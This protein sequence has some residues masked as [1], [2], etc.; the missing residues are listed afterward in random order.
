MAVSVVDIQVNSSGAVRSLQQL[1][2]AA[3]GVT[4]TI[5][6][7]AA[8]LGA[9]F[10]LQQV[11][12]TASEFEST[13]S[14]IGKTAGSSQKDILKLADSL[15]QL[16]MPSRTNLAPSV[17]A[18]GVQDLVAQGLKLDD[19]VASIETLGKVAV[20]T[21]SDLTD[22]T[23]TGFQ[24][25]SALKI[26]PTELKATFD[27]L[28]FAGKAGAFELKDMAQFMPTIASAAA[29]LGIQGKDGAVALASM[30]QMVRK[31]AP[32]AAEASTRLTDA[33]LKMTA[34]E[35]VKNFKKFGVDIEAVLKNAVKNGV[36][37]MDAAIKELIRVTGN[38]PFKLSQIFGDKE[39]KLALMSLMKYK[40]EYEKLKALAG[41]T[42]A[43]GT[44]QADFDKSLKTFDQQFKSLTNAGEILAL[45]LGKTLM[46]V[47]TAL[48]KE[49]TP[50]VT[51]I[52]NLVQGMGQIPKPVIDAA[53]QV[54]KLI[55][56]VTL[57]SKA[58]GIATGA[59]ALLRGA[60]VLLNTQ[61]LLSASAAMT[62]NAK[63]L[64]LAGGMNTAASRAAILRGVLTGLAVIGIITVGINLVTTGL[65]EFIAAQNEINR[66]RGLRQGGGV[67]LVGGPTQTRENVIK[68]QETAKQTIVQTTQQ[69]K[70]AQ[71]FDPISFFLGG[72]APLVGGKSQ[73]Q[74][75][76]AFRIANE[77]QLN[78]QSILG[79]SPLAF[80]PAKP[81]KPELPITPAGGGGVTPAGGGGDDAAK[82]A[83]KL[84]Q[85]LA[86]DSAQYQMQIDGQVFRNQVDLDKLRYDL[87]RQLQEKEFD[88]FVNKFTGVAREQAG[89]IQSAVLGS[90]AFDTQIKELENKIKEAQQRLQSGTRM[91]QVQSTTVAGG[92]GGGFSTSQLNTAAQAAS[93]FTGVANMCSESVKA[94]YGSLGITLPGVTA[95]ADSVRKAGT[96]MTDFSKIKPG[97]ILASNKPGGPRQHVGVYTGGQNVFHQSSSRG[98]KAGNYPDLNSFKGGYF[99]RPNAA[100][101]GGAASVPG[102]NVDQT[103]TEIQG[104]MQQLAL[105][106]SQAKSFT[107]VDLTA[108][109]L[110][111]T[112]AF[113]EQ[114]AQ[115][116]LQ[117]EAFTLR[118]RLQMEGVKPELI[119]GELKLLEVRQQLNDRLKPF[120]ELVAAGTMTQVQYAEATD[121]IKT[122][123]E[124][125]AVAIQTYTAA[126]VAASS[127][128]QQFIGSAQTQLNDLESVA[129]RVSQSIGDAVGSSLTKG[130]QGLVEGT[131][132]AKQ[133]FADFLQ[134]VS[135]ILM[136][137]ATKMI[138]TYTAIAIAKS[139]AGLFGGGSSAIVGGSTYGGAASSS[140]F[141]A[142]TGTAFGGMKAKGG[143]VT[144]GTPYLVGERGPELFMPGRSGGI[145]PAGSFGGGTNVVVNVDATGSNVQGDDQSS[146]QLGVL[147]AAAVQ[148]ELIKQKRPGGILA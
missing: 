33:L 45:S 83:A 94:F 126:T 16:S 87:Q 89:I 19:A 118:N 111:S 32:G 44:I 78:A 69:K 64:L 84:A 22:V 56:Q 148:K 57:V 138:A 122:A 82:K 75:T 65:S 140:I 133:V 101:G 114:T 24:L 47:L 61:V 104:L 76:D 4:A 13:L 9:G 132:T 18:K 99:V 121:G 95:L 137:E 7:L 108:F 134:T 81:A 15:K 112:S 86:M 42:A 54:G 117:T 17:L 72:L 1:N 68:K 39:A 136:Q 115:L 14:D 55:L 20:A 124:A 92:G 79:L 146:K 147:L 34:P 143:S 97:D 105:L 125:A 66:L 51:G 58:I 53:I 49:I 100:M 93:K 6:S 48:I 8:A 38:D 40:D 141:S 70:E 73:I 11:I 74:K 43:S 119:D 88:N 145:A 90:A 10:A 127:P 113:R 5:G 109:I 129:V 2:V 116:G 80:A 77:K 28:A 144:G 135:N 23:K 21:N 37:P 41:G 85:K 52:S 3:K 67:Q 50:I 26:K 107:A 91:N 96:V 131:T 120:N 27:A 59:A 25:Q 63:M 130:V 35:S 123:A 106:K 103:K 29:S 62:G 30:M 102:E 46:P 98:L 142:G 139:L 12:R 128:I 60:F 36:N 31:D 110:K 71:K